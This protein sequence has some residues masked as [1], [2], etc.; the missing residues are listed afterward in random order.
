MLFDKATS[1][2]DPELVGDV[3]GVFRDLAAEGMTILVT[4]EIGFA[5]EVA[6]QV[7]FMRD[8][9]VAEAGPPASV[10]DQPRNEATRSFLS[11]FKAV[12]SA[13]RVATTDGAV[14][15]GARAVAAGGTLR[16]G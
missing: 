10:I 15:P 7:I 3:L 16:A 4:H 1:A 11:R 14:A 13:Q 6:D 8:G 2:L 9:V 12:S 5:S